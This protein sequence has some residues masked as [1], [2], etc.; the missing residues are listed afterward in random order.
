MKIAYLSIV[1][2]FFLSCIKCAWSDNYKCTGIESGFKI[3]SFNKDGII[4]NIA[5]R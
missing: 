1:L 5:G 2:T 4:I 3:V